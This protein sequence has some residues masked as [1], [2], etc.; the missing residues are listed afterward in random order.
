ITLSLHDALPI[1]KTM[2][3]LHFFIKKGAIHGMIVM[4]HNGH[5]RSIPLVRIYS[6]EEDVRKMAYIIGCILVIIA[7]IIVALIMRKR[8]YDQ[9]DRNEEWKLDILNRDIASQ[10]SRIKRL[11][12]SGE[13]QE[14]FETWKERWEQIVS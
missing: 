14:K 8:I 7:S 2:I 9:V 12:L 5:V 10:L 11:N 13:T 4:I 6:C 3:N 1:F